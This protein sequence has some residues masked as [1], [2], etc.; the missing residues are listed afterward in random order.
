MDGHVPFR[1]TPEEAA[2]AGQRTAEHPD[3]LAAGCS[4]AAEAERKRFASVLADYD[5]LPDGEKFLA[6]FRHVR[7]LYDS[8]DPAACASAVEA[9]R[10]N[11]VAVTADLGRVSPRRVC[12][13]GPFG[14]SP[15]ATRPPGDPP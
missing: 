1:V 3:A 13:A 15:Y 8:R 11:G 4:I 2:D 6:M 10:R 14:P 7:A 5:R 9:Y 12:G